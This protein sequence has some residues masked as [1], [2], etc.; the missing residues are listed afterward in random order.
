[1]EVKPGWL[2]RV[3]VSS[4]NREKKRIEKRRIKRGET[5]GYNGLG[6]IKLMGDGLI[7]FGWDLAGTA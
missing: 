1:M 6:F 2:E 4:E 3:S 7:R 5:K